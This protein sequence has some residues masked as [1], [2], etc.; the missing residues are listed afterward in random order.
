MESSLKGQWRAE[1]PSEI[2]VPGALS[3]MTVRILHVRLPG[4]YWKLPMM[5]MSASQPGPGIQ[6]ALLGYALG[7][8]PSEALGFA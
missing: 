8:R 6:E 5:P 1:R 2:Q 4:T 3:P 7:M